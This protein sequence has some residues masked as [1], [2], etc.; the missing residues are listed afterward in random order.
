MSSMLLTCVQY[1]KLLQEHVQITEQG[2]AGIE[3]NKKKNSKQPN[4]KNSINKI[5]KLIKNQLQYKFRC[6]I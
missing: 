5:E 2:A 1:N 6:V 4:S 3:Q